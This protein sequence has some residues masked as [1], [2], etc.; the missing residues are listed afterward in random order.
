MLSIRILITLAIFLQATECKDSTAKSAETA[1]KTEQS[2]T[3]KSQNETRIDSV[4]V[5]YYG[6]MRGERQ[7]MIV[8]PT[9]TSFSFKNIDLKEAVVQ[10]VETPADQWKKLNQDFDS[11]KFRDLK[12]GSSKVVFDGMDYKFTVKGAFGEMTVTNPLDHTTGMDAF[13]ETLKNSL[14]KM[15]ENREN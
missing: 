15:N 7:V 3:S 8:T 1:P 6:G 13:F 12:N 10:K 4:V 2:D 14:Q 9:E 5:E 11:K